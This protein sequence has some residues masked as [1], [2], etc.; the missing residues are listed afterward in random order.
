MMTKPAPKGGVCCVAM[1][2]D[3]AWSPQET[4]PTTMGYSSGTPHSP[5]KHRKKIVE[6][7]KQSETKM[8]NVLYKRLVV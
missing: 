2:M 3:L 4:T 5:K 6:L 7:K 1:A 8:V